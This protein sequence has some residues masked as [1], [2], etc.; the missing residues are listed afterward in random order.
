MSN[1]PNCAKTFS[2]FFEDCVILPCFREAKI[3]P[4]IFRQPKGSLKWWIYGKIKS[5][6]IISMKKTTSQ[7]NQQWIDAPPGSIM[8]CF[9]FTD[10]LEALWR[11]SAPN[12]FV[13][14]FDKLYYPSL[15]LSDHNFLTARPVLFCQKEKRCPLKNSTFWAPII[16]GFIKNQMSYDCLNGK[17]YKKR[18]QVRNPSEAIISF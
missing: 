6:F 5:I 18:S 11:D 3:F 15:S 7:N 9:W 1:W 16:P 17:D 8:A 14:Q 4:A 2:F 10:P 12:F 13:R